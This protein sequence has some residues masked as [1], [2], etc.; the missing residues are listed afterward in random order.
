MASI[1][2]PKSKIQNQTLHPVILS[3]PGRVKDLKPKERV[4]FL[5]RHARRALEMSA[6]KSGIRLG[7][8]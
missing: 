7:K 6:E 5:S 8:L 2:N 3:V 4:K 1:R